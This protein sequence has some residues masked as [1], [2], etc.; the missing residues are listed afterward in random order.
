[1]LLPKLLKLFL[2]KFKPNWSGGH[3]LLLSQP[4]EDLYTQMQKN[5]MKKQILDKN[6]VNLQKKYVS[7]LSYI[8]I[9]QKQ[10]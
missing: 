4:A 10:K 8:L 7:K 9:F 3:I 2:P 5:I 6:M 1:L